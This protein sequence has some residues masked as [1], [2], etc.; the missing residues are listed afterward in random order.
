MRYD[1]QQG[2]WL[3][4]E[5]SY[6]YTCSVQIGLHDWI[7]PR[8]NNAVF[9]WKVYDHFTQCCILRTINPCKIGYCLYRSQD[10]FVTVDKKK[11][12][13]TKY[14]HNV[15]MVSAFQID[16]SL[17]NTRYILHIKLMYYYNII[18]TKY[19][20]IENNNG[21][22]STFLHYKTSLFIVMVCVLTNVCVKQRTCN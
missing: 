7:Q 8:R 5:Y 12:Q 15:I 17:N 13:H 6:S 10:M 4:H 11:T 18:R 14:I 16:R 2:Y 21:F 19:S 9:F 22:I 1:I 3:N 20:H